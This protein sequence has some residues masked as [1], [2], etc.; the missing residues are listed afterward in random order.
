VPPDL[1]PDAT[2][3]GLLAKVSRSAS[4]DTVLVIKLSQ[5]GHFDLRQ[6]AIPGMPWKQL[7][8][9][10]AASPDAQRWCLFG[11]ALVQPDYFPFDYPQGV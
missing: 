9:F 7:W 2:L 4:T 8:F 3:D 10:W 1:N 5:P 6:L 11:D